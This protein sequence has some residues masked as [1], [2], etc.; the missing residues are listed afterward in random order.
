MSRPLAVRV[1]IVKLAR[2]LEREPESLSYLDAVAPEEIRVLRDQTTEVLFKANGTTLTRLAAAS[3]LLPVGVVATIGERA[4]GPRLSARMAA[5]LDPD[6][7]VEMASK[8]P[9]EFLA[10]VAV[11]ID[12][13]R[14]KD[15]L[16]GIPPDQVAAITR[17]LARRQEYVTI[18]RFVG[19]LPDGAIRAGLDELDD[20]TLLRVAFV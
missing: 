15:L 12:P 2:L 14:A 3:R 10:D 7:A 17:E 4:F 1:E 5:L 8:L 6:R 11:D 19:Q 13:R 20:A 16:A 18:G 9:V